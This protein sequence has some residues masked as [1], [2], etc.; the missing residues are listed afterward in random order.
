MQEQ[1]TM[2]RTIFINKSQYDGSLYGKMSWDG[3]E[4][5]VSTKMVQYLLETL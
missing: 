4:Y 1:K 3:E 2:Y 5:V